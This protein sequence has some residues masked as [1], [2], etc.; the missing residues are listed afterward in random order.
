MNAKSNRRMFGTSACTALVAG[1]FALASP[2][3]V[4]AA[5][6]K[7]PA[8]GES[9]V[10]DKIRAQGELRAGSAIGAPG[11]LQDPAT[12]KLVG[13]AMI[14]GQAI[15][16]QLKV[17]F[18]LVQSNWDVIIAGL[19]AD[20]YEIAI[21]PLLA[22][23]KRLQVVDIVPY[24]KDGLCYSVLK[25]NPK[26]ANITKSE[27]LDRS[28]INWSTVTGSASETLLPT[29]FTKPKFRSVQIPPGG[30]TATDEV[31]SG[32]ADVVT[33][34]ATQAK[35]IEARFPQIRMIPPADEC[36]AKPDFEVPV[37]M[38]I[39]KGDPV[40]VKFMTAVVSSLEP[41]INAAMKKYTSPE[42]MIRK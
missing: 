24:Y 41:Q 17:K 23:E 31:L 1:L 25:T 12:G 26:T 35:V 3:L 14:I 38:A 40:M 19:Q 2:G 11:L 5:D 13:P 6:V 37:G 36:L 20:R 42:F 29:K 27:Q 33:Q 4:L 7:V 21:A 15:A 16:D 32:R 10:I 28:D 30:A 34:N 22:T 18:V 8:K 39:I 9:A